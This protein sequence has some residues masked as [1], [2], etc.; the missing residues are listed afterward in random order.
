[1]LNG[2]GEKQETIVHPISEN[3]IQIGHRNYK[4]NTGTEKQK[5]DRRKYPTCGDS[6]GKCR[7]VA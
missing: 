6:E 4:H 7:T 5:N 1:M 3:G 2:D